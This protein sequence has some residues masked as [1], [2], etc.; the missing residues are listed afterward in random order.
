M[1]ISDEY[2]AEKLA[3][4]ARLDLTLPA[5]VRAAIGGY[6]AVMALPVP[7]PPFRGADRRAITALADELARDA[8]IGK[9]P[10]RPPQPLDVTPIR[11]AR[12]DDQ[13]AHDRAALARELRA[14]SAVVLCQVFGGDIGQ[15]VIEALQARHAEVIDGLCKRARRLPPGADEQTALQAGGQVRLDYLA[16]VD[17]V[18]TLAELRT[19]LRL[20]DPGT[21]PEPDDGMA[22]CS[23]WEQTG[24]LA[25]TWMAPTGDTTHGT[26]GTLSWWLSVARQDGYVLWLPTAAEQ[27]ARLAEL[28]HD[29]QA[30]RLAAR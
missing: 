27:A 8:I 16:A 25:Q 28:R 20:V 23:H 10:A 19:A 26:P 18:A 4:L 9:H 21:P 17:A 2:R 3:A 5:P 1:A 30:Q 29:R 15:Q 11:Q 12:Q 14:A 24:K 7:A 6:E 13:D 22:A